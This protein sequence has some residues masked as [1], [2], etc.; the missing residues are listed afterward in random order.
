[1]ILARGAMARSLFP[2]KG[3]SRMRRLVMLL[4]IA[5]STVFGAD[6][7]DLLLAIRDGD[8]AR[9]QKI[10]RAGADVNTRDGDG[11]TALMHSVIESDVSMM[12]LLLDSGAE[13][14][15]KNTH[16]STAL[17]YAAVS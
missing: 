16:G 6:S 3:E 10:L 17:M 13:V 5:F 11:T 9:V 15:A 7:P 14:D 1:M 12:K 2:T 8:H 4:L